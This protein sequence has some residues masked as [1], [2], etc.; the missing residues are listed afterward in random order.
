M[1]SLNHKLA[2]QALVEGKWEDLQYSVNDGN[3]QRM[4]SEQDV[5][6]TIHFANEDTG[7]EVTF[8]HKPKFTRQEKFYVIK[9][10]TVEKLKNIDAVLYGRFLNVVEE[11]DAKLANHGIGHKQTVVIEDDWP[12]Y[13]KVWEMVENYYES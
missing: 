8:R 3:W 5:L 11:I 12:M 9:W 1:I 7:V 10:N 6:K 2:L 4:D 13:D